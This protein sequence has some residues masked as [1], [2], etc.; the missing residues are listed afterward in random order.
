MCVKS[1]S[2]NMSWMIFLKC[3]LYLIALTSRI[4]VTWLRLGL[5]AR[6]TPLLSSPMAGFVSFLGE[7]HTLLAAF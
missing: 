5:L 6:V 7:H 4:F 1:E 3:R 2:R